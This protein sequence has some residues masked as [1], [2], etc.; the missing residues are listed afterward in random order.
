MCGWESFPGIGDLVVREYED[1]V[2]VWELPGLEQLRR[3]SRV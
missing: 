2:V 3:D 1:D